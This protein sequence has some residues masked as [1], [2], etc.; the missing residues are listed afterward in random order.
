MTP[1]VYKEN[2]GHISEE[3]VGCKILLW[4]MGKVRNTASKA[5]CGVSWK[6]R[7]SPVNS[8]HCLFVCLINFA[9]VE[10]Q[11]RH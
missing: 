3:Y 6:L 1:P 9:E 4:Q 11:K 2:Q 8:F 10:R 5:V 7:K